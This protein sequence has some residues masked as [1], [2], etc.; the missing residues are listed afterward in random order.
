MVSQPAQLTLIDDQPYELEAEPELVR[1][2]RLQ[3]TPER[4]IDFM[5]SLEVMQGP[6][7]GRNFEVLPYQRRVIEALYGKRDADDGAL[8][9]ARANGKTTFSSYLA[10]AFIHPDG[11]LHEPR[12]EVVTI[13]SSFM[14]ARIGF[15]ATL[16]ALQ[17]TIDRSRRDW[18][19]EDS[20]NRASITYR[21]TGA[22]CRVLG[23]DPARAH[24]LQPAICIGDEPGQWPRHQ[25]D[26]MLS[27]IRTARG[28]LEL[29][30]F[31]AIGT[32]S[33]ETSHWFER[34]LRSSG[35]GV[36]RQVHSA[37]P[38]RD[39]FR[40]STI[41]QANPAL[42]HLPALKRA[43]RQEAR[44]A[45][46]TPSLLPSYRALRLNIP[47]SDV[48]T[49]PLV[50]LEDYRAA[51][52][53]ETPAAALASW[54][55]D[56]AETGLAAVACYWP[57]TGR[58]DAIGAVPSVPDLETRGRRYGIGDLYLEAHA[59]GDLIVTPGRSVDLGELL[60]AAYERFG[61]PTAITYDGHRAAVLLD[62][63]D[64][65]AFPIN[66][67]QLHKRTTVWR[68]GNEDVTW[69]RR[70]FGDGD[71]RPVPNRVLRDGHD[72]ATIEHDAHGNIRLLRTGK[73]GSRVPDDAASAAVLAVSTACRE[74]RI[75]RPSHARA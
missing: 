22:V 51:E 4:I 52:S 32:R 30:K 46:E 34:M 69:Y 38:D 2:A 33:A 31:L 16:A 70:A 58:L 27:A 35:R 54:G 72:W 60:H 24:G 9:L 56:V 66:P 10:A 13:A 61:P 48:E 11:P 49:A 74:P 19:V 21:P 1:A 18:K 53:A 65:S 67:G 6:L 36:Y 17:P 50:E 41:R 71:V 64:R 45:Q 28:K 63:L 73:T 68:E 59:D 62:A 37:D 14:Q 15:G 3:A 75:Q 57:T 47:T 25:R 42:D 40:L 8:S 55:I 5:Q 39:P 43:I 12:G 23:S 44:A 20:S 7:R 26:R 29:S